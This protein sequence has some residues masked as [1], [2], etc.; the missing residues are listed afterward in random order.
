MAG[1]EYRIQIGAM[2]RVGMA[3]EHGIEGGPLTHRQRRGDPIAGVD[4]EGV[5]ISLDEVATARLASTRVP[6]T[7]PDH[8][9]PH[10]R[11]IVAAPIAFGVFTG[12]I[13]WI[14][15][16]VTVIAA[17]AWQPCTNSE[18]GGTVDGTRLAPHTI[19]LRC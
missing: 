5:A 19:G 13:L 18:S 1:S 15:G 10:R 7:S 11:R 12:S 14:I 9:E 2:V 17:L 16:V 8:R 6:A 4:E 3:D